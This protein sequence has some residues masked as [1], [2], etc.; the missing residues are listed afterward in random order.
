M[1]THPKSNAIL[2]SMK[3]AYQKQKNIK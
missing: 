1:L 3:G 2:S